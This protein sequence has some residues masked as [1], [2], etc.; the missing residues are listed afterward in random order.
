[1]DELDQKLV[2]LLALDSR[3]KVAGLA[4]K[5]KIPASTAA[6]RV[7]KLVKS[8][9]LKRFTIE[10]DYEKAGKPLLALCQV[11][12]RHSK[13]NPDD[14]IQALLKLVD[15][16][17]VYST[18]GEWDFTIVIRTQDIKS[19]KKLVTYDLKASLPDIVRSNTLI[20]LE[21]GKK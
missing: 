2:E 11:S 14:T 12:V 15:V 18:T 1:M 6:A 10:L 9:L 20:A 16:R 13:N 5:L 17:E 8:G 7:V 19:L 3:I 4:K 21:Y